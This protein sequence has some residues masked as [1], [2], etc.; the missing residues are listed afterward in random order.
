MPEPPRVYL[1]ANVYLAWLRGEEGRVDTARELLTA[2]Q[3]RR[4]TIVASTL[5]HAEVCG[6]GEVRSAKAV[7]VDAKIRAF[8]DRG[9]LRW[10]EVDLPTARHARMLS[11]EYGLRGA[12]AVHLASAIRGRAET[13][14]TWDTKDFPIGQAVEGVQVQVPETE[15]QGT[16]AVS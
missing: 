3:E 6:H 11:R 8:F 13:F 9:F 1:D 2:G 14:M 7:D 15:G 4:L 16:F 10:V 12:D 5:V